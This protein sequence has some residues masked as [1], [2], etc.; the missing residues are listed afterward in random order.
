MQYIDKEV[1]RCK[2]STTR[3]F[4]IEKKKT[5]DKVLTRKTQEQPYVD[6]L[7]Q[8]ERQKP[9]DVKVWNIN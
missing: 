1:L 7:E 6:A 4:F 5:K 8:E 2:G 9:K 3:R